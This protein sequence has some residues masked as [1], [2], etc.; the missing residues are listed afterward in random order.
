MC[1]CDVAYTGEVHSEET[2][3]SALEDSE[4]DVEGGLHI[5]IAEEELE[6]II[7]RKTEEG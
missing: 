4:N 7:A 1:A 3:E 5:R 2:R 6:N